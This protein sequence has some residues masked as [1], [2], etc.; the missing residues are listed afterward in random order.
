[1]W[2]L[3]TTQIVILRTFRP[4]I[5]QT[6]CGKLIFGKTLHSFDILASHFFGKMIF[7]HNN[8]LAKWYFGKMA[9]WQNNTLAKLYLGTMIL[10]QSSTLANWYFGKMIAWDTRWPLSK[11]THCSKQ[12][13]LHI[14]SRKRL[15]IWMPEKPPIQRSLIFTGARIMCY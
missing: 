8:T 6:N 12:T 14:G 11:Q 15:Q 3:G 5:L 1:M 7:W 13:I 10:W 9:L 4:I 2:G